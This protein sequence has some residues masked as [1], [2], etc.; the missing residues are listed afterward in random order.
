MMTVKC[1]PCSPHRNAYHAEP[2]RDPLLVLS[3]VYVES[4]SEV[5]PLDG[6]QD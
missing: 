1:A 4:D 3:R 6:V 5:R 2:D